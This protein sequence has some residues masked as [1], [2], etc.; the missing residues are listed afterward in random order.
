[1]FIAEIGINHNGSLDIAKE[2]IKIAKDCGVDVVKFQKRNP[3]ICVPESQKNIIK[4]TVFG[5]MRYIDYKYK[6][7]FGKDEYDEIDKYCKEIGILW[8]SS[9]WDIDSLNF[10]NNY[11]VPFIKLASACI[12]DYK[13]IEKLNELRIPVII[14]TGMSTEEEIDNAIN[15]LKDNLIGILH[16]NSSYP[17]KNEEIDLNY[18]S[19]LKTKYPK[20]QI[21]YSGHEKGYLP[22]IIAKTLGADILER[23]IT[24]DKNMKGSDHKASLNPKELK[25]LMIYIKSIPNIMGGFKKNIYSS[26]IEMRNKLRKS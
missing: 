10:I 7:E 17:S 1:M 2:L 9:V 23:H 20:Y 5:E 22:T 26:E 13:L 12:T 11:D 25:Q 24:L 18:M 4:D 19:I 15:L 14:S 3:D 8:T 16:C 6:I 21:G